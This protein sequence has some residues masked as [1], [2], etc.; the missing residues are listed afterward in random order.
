ML[1]FSN[2]RCMLKIESWDFLMMTL[3]RLLSD[4]GT[5]SKKFFTVSSIIFKVV[6][7]FLEDNVQYVLYTD[8]PS[9]AAFIKECI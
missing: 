7:L 3:F 2:A 1:G 4:D 8:K 6:V 9:A 5:P